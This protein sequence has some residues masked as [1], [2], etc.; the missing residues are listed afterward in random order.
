MW[1]GIHINFILFTC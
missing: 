1:T